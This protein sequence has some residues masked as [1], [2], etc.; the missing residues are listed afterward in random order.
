M[1]PRSGKKTKKTENAVGVAPSARKDVTPKWEEDEVNK[2]NK[3]G[4][5][6]EE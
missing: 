3:V 5:A 1:L 6:S 2:V 4:E